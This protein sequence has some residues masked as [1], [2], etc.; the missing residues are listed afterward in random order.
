MTWPT[1]RKRHPPPTQSMPLQ[2][3]NCTT[4]VLL[5]QYSGLVACIA[6]TSFGCASHTRVWVANGCRGLFAASRSSPR[7]VCGS[8]ERAPRHECDLPKV[9]EDKV[10]LFAPSDRSALPRCVCHN[11]GFG[12]WNML[13]AVVPRAAHE[14]FSGVLRHIRWRETR[15]VLR[16]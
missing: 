6:N 4:P 10:A 13:A 7:V 5:K 15:P 12:W 16:V 11:F 1:P 9:G 2:A 8:L 14:R 3:A